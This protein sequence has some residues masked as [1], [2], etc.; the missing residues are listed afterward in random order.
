MQHHISELYG[1]KKKKKKDH[2]Q[3][4]ISKLYGFKK[5]KKKKGLKLEFMRTFH[6]P[7]CFS[8]LNRAIRQSNI[9]ALYFANN[10]DLFVLFDTN[11][12]NANVAEKKL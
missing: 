8:W 2:M 4:H 7:Q 11:K 10:F 12:S 1:F 9:L 6:C 3:H 5:K